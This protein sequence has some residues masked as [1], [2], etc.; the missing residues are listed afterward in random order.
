MNWNLTHKKTT[1]EGAIYFGFPAGATNEEVQA[2]LEAMFSKT[3]YMDWF[4][5]RE[6]CEV[7]VYINAE[8]YID[9][10]R[11]Q[12]DSDSESETDDE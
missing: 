2:K 4:I 3:P 11:E 6:D 12:D 8:R 10:K 7:A 9:W 1:V 5:I